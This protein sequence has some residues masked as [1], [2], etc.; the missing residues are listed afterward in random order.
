MKLLLQIRLQSF[1]HA[2]FFWMRIHSM[3]QIIRRNFFYKYRIQN[4][5]RF[6][7][8]RIFEILVK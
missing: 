1:V 5:K 2:Y 7:S 8:I 6:L 4:T 3:F